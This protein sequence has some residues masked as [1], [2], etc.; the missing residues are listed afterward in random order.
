V[1]WLFLNHDGRGEMRRFTG[2]SWAWRDQQKFKTGVQ[3]PYE[4]FRVGHWSVI[5]YW[6]AGFE[7][8]SNWNPELHINHFYVIILN[9][10]LSLSDG[11]T[12]IH[13]L[14]A[15]LGTGILAMPQAF[16]YAGLLNGIIATILVS[17]VCTYCSYILVRHC[18][19]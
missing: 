15:S 17:I 11:E 14:K 6:L 8:F 9:F 10:T 4:N 13:L 12:L 3:I 5:I 1:Q 2:N 16:Y 19:I 7:F 18:H